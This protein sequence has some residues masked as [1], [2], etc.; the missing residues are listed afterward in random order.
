MGAGYRPD[1]KPLIDAAFFGAARHAWTPTGNRM[2]GMGTN[3]SS[4]NIFTL[5]CNN[6]KERNKGLSP[7]NRTIYL[8]GI[9]VE[10]LE[11]RPNGDIAVRVSA[12]DTRINGDVRWC[13]DSIVLPPCAARMADRSPSRQVHRC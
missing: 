11:Q 10:L 6:K 9:R 3:P 12:G 4:A 7:D 13:A 5:G 1:G 8:N 2:L